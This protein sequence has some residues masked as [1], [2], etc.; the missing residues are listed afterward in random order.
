MKTTKFEDRDEWLE[1]RKTKITGSRLKDIVVLRGNEKKIGFWELL[2]ERLQI[3]DGQNENPM[4][5]GTDLESEAIM[6]FEEHEGKK[7][8]TDLV[9]WTREDNES[10]AISPDGF[11]GETEAVECKCLAS[12]RH[13]EAYFTNK[14]PKD[15]WFQVLQ[16][17][18]VN[19]KLELLHFVMY[20]P[21]IPQKPYFKFTVD[22]SEVAEEVEQ[23]LE[24][25]RKVLEEV[26]SLANQ[27]SF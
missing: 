3:K 23:Y 22:R 13:L 21:R 16:Y 4:Q 17:F 12:S 2:A 7:V 27:L 14:I 11:I 18:I 1:A 19:E 9:I 26:N 10:I 24:Y 20:D 8:N 25:Q 6:A 5:R 15:Y